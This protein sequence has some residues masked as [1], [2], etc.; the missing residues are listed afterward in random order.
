[1]LD[2]KEIITI[3]RQFHFKAELH[4]LR[5]PW[6]LAEVNQEVSLQVEGE[7]LEATGKDKQPGQHSHSC[8]FHSNCCSQVTGDS[9]G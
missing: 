8:A 9:S 5:Q 7:L 2:R 3:K 1:M 4:L 6:G